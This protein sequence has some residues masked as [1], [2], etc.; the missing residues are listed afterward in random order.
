MAI[1]TAKQRDKFVANALKAAEAHAAGKS[2]IKLGM[3]PT[4]QVLDLDTGGYCAR[5]V[6]QVAETTLGIAP[7]HWVFAAASARLMGGKLDRADLGFNA[8]G[9]IIGVGTPLQPGD[10]LV[11]EDVDSGK[12]GHVAIYLGDCYGDGRKLVAENTSSAKRGFPMRAGTKITQLRNMRGS[13]AA[14]RLFAGVL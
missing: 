12:F 4:A 1:Y 7:M 10:I 3:K 5:F 11:W 6:R 9:L 2:T 14:Y 13:W 8:A